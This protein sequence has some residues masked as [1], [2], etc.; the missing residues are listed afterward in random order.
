MAEEI[1]APLKYALDTLLSVARLWRHNAMR[2]TAI[3]AD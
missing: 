3:D 2:A 1:T